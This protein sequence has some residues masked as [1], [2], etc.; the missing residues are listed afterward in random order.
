M[1]RRGLGELSRAPPFGLLERARYYYIIAHRRNHRRVH[2][3]HAYARVVNVLLMQLQ[4]KATK[5]RDTGTARAPA[6]PR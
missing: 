6:I 5:L 1:H 4:L 2:V 3:V